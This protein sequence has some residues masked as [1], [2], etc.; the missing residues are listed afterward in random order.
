[1]ALHTTSGRWQLGFFLAATS[2]LL[3]GS[4]PI[5]LSIMLKSIDPYTLTWYRLLGA[6]LILGVFLGANGTLP[7]LWSRPK[8]K[9]V[10]LLIGSIGLCGNYI[11]YLLGLNHIT[12]SSAQVVIQV[13]PLL[14]LLGGLIL[15]KERFS[16][17]QSLGVL[18]FCVGF[19]LFFHPDLKDILSGIGSKP[20]GVFW[21]LCAATSWSVYALLQKQLLTDFTSPQIMFLI[22]VIIG[23]VLLPLTQPLAAIDLTPSQL[24]I[25]LFCVLNSLIAYGS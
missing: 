1:M 9:L 2:T 16:K 3:W 17:V 7:K 23:L 4:L 13:A 5:A 15:F 14:L 12:P 6:G 22:Y 19:A 25:L 24:G 10:M 21:I 18:I 8:S 20:K 11:F